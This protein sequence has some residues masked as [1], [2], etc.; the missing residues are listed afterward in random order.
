MFARPCELFPVGVIRAGMI[1]ADAESSGT[2]TNEFPPSEIHFLELAQQKYCD[3][4]FDLS[5][6]LSRT[7]QGWLSRE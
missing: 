4:L 6:T 7:R 2:Q 3:S 1:S 5:D